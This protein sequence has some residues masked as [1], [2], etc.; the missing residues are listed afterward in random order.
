MSHSVQSVI[1]VFLRASSLT[2][3]SAVGSIR[4]VFAKISGINAKHG[5]FDLVLCVGDFFG[6]V[7]DEGTGS[8][9]VL[10]LLNGDIQ[11]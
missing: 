4:D 7:D 8:A 1:R 11:G 2:V 6:P 3:G 5:K 10:Q 9:E